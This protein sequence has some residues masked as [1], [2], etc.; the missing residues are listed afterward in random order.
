MR[1]HL[2]S[3][4]ILTYQATHKKILAPVTLDPTPRVWRHRNACFH[5]LPNSKKGFL[6]VGPIP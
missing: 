1:N 2:V 4:R 3:V 5:V 6:A